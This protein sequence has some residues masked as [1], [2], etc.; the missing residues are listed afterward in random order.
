M[1]S[2]NT[3][4]LWYDGSERA[5]GWCKEK[6]GLSWQ[7]TPRVLID[8]ITDPRVGSPSRSTTCRPRTHT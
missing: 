6:W 5:C 2:K 4:C 8:T 7:I 1:T 3:I